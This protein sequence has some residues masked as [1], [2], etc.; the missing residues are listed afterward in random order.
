MKLV[1]LTIVRRNDWLFKV[2]VND[3]TGTILIHAFNETYQ[4]SHFR[5]FD[6]E[7]RASNWVDYLMIQSKE[8]NKNP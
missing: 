2:S 3:D 7:E 1:S 6:S 8:L 5:F 4:W